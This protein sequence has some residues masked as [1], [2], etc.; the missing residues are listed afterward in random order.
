MLKS[1]IIAKSFRRI[2]LTW[3][4]KTAD[5]IQCKW[6]TVGSLHVFPTQCEALAVIQN[7]ALVTRTLKSNLKKR[8]TSKA[9]LR[10]RMWKKGRICGI[11]PWLEDPHAL[12]VW[13]AHRLVPT[14]PSHLQKVSS[15]C[16]GIVTKRH[17]T[18]LAGSCC[19]APS[20]TTLAGTK[21][22]DE[23]PWGHVT[24]ACP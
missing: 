9:E 20:T 11:R 4:S 3:V 18:L 16:W 23:I 24:Q 7:A 21:M 2:F 15:P 1:R 19:P 13:D 12:V 14:L 8:A 6:K 5:A 17:P 10:F 22:E